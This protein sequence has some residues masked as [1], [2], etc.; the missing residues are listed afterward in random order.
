MVWDVGGLGERTD[1]CKRTDAL[2]RKLASG[3]KA[4]AERGAW[5]GG[6][7]TVAFRPEIQWGVGAA[8]ELTHAAERPQCSLRASVGAVAG[9]R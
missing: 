6:I 4:V 1:I 5:K 8:A 9:A 3:G 2:I 7:N